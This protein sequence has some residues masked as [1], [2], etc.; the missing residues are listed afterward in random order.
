[1]PR[2]LCTQETTLRELKRAGGRVRPTELSLEEGM[3]CKI[4]DKRSSQ[5]NTEI[6]DPDFLTPP[7]AERGLV[8]EF[9][10][11]L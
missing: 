7:R 4:R 9:E 5:G 10:G 8:E 11:R 2:W 1:M 6:G 3:R